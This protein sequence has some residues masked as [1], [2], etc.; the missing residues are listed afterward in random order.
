M[1]QLCFA[2]SKASFRHWKELFG[3]SRWKEV[4]LLAAANLLLS[5]YSLTTDVKKNMQTLSAAHPLVFSRYGG[6]SGSHAGN[7]LGVLDLDF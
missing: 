2:T 3:A 1:Y 5:K 4:Q 7:Q 6:D